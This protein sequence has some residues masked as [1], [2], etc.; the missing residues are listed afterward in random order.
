[1][2]TCA[3]PPETIQILTDGPGCP[4]LGLVE[5]AGFSRAVVWP[6]VGAH[7]RSMHRICL[8]ADARTAVQQHPTE[9]VYYVIAGGGAVAEPA[10]GDRQPLRP[11]S[12]VH[13]EAGTS[14]VLSAGPDGCD[15]VGGP[16]PPDERLYAHLADA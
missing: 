15:L 13:V 2:R 5:G 8:E 6:G 7:K 4:D 1:M 12:M 9:A 11:G 3:P 10:A 16:C 14:Y